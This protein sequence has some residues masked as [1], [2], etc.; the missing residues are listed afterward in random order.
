M[1]I[2][3]EHYDIIR[4]PI[5]TEKTMAASQHRGVVFEVAIDANKASIKEA[6]EALYGVKV[7]AVNT[8]I[9][10]GKAVRF[11]YRFQGKTR[12]RKKAYITLAEGNTL[13]VF[14]SL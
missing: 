1:T 13:D 14:S 9:S 8:S 2:K 5:T 4:R 12:A 10:K 6:V 3:P 11:R 7:Q